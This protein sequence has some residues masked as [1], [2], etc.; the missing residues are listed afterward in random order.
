MKN[1]YNI[2]IKH[3]NDTTSI[4]KKI[5]LLYKNYRKESNGGKL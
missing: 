4:V 5:V 1:I 3:K 2:N